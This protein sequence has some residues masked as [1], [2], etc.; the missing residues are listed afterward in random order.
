M[1]LVLRARDLRQSGCDAAV[2]R[3]IEQTVAICQ[4]TGERW[5]AEVLCTEGLVASVG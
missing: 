5:G 1:F 3:G 4:D 2:L